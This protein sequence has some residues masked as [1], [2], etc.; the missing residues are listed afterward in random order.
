MKPS[1][2]SVDE[3]IADLPKHEQVV[4]KR[5][6]SLIL[7]CL[8]KAAEKNNYGVRFYTRNR[9]ICF[10]WPPSIYWGRRK[11]IINKKVLRSASARAT[12]LPMK[13]LPYW[14]RVGSRFTACT[15][16][17]LMKSMKNKSGRCCSKLIS[18]ISSL[19]KTKGQ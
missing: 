1:K 15:S 8:P 4:V 16:T 10:I 18:L 13:M 12:C 19:G 17:G 9:M 7:E 14:L 11:V 3:I 6:R 5:L 2:K